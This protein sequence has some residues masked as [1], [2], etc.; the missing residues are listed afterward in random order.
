VRE[1]PI[2]FS[3]SMVQAILEG[4]KTQTRRAVKPQPPMYFDRHC[5]FDAPV[6]GWTR[7]PEPATDWHK[8]KCPYGVPGDRLWVRETFVRG[9]II[10]SEPEEPI[11]AVY[12]QGTEPDFKGNAERAKEWGEAS[13]MHPSAPAGSEHWALSW[14][15]KPGIFMP[16]WAS[17]I[18]LE[19]VSVRVERVNAI[20]E[21]DAI[22]EGVKVV[23]RS[24]FGKP[25]C[26]VWPGHGMDQAGLCHTAASTA[27][28]MGWDSI[29]GKQY[30][31]ETNP[32]VWAVEFRRVG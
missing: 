19:V 9:K 32:W 6:Y 31:W 8:A 13:K 30:P 12:L 16:R 1:R 25:P 4:R 21:A 20:S 22:A 24:A 7:E 5:W 29:N 11:M 28:S 26:Y 23:D 14:K 2:L 17:R 3:S 15:R 18:T 27:Y 10:D